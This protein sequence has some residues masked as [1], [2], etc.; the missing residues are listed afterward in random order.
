MSS[1][2]EKRLSSNNTVDI[3]KIDN[4]AISRL[5]LYPKRVV[6]TFAIKPR[7]RCPLTRCCWPTVMPPLP[8]LP[9]LSGFPRLE[10]EGAAPYTLYD[11]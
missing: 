5:F 3:N 6:T 1:Y 7:G 8:P 9:P 2:S 11:S 10:S 4:M